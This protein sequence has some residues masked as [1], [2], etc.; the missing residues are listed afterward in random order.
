MEEQNNGVDIG[1][2]A[3][4]N[5]KAKMLDHG[6]NSQTPHSVLGRRDYSGTQHVEPV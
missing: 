5:G 6:E 1:N 3:N 2:T 4:F